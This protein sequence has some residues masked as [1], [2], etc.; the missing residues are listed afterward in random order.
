MKRLHRVSVAKQTAR[1]LREGLVAVENGAGQSRRVI[2]DGAVGAAHP[3]PI[4]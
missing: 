2:H 3:H 1:H 4:R